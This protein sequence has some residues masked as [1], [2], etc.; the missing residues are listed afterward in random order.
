MTD[1]STR[2][3]LLWEVER[4]L[5]ELQSEHK[6]IDC[7]VM[8]NVPAI[9]SSKDYPNFEKWLIR[10]EELG[11]E[12][13]W[14]DINSKRMGI[15]QNRDRTFCVSVPKGY[16]VNKPKERKLKILLQDVL[17]ENVSEKYFLNDKMIDYIYREDDVGNYHRKAAREC[18][19]KSIEKGI[20]GS[21]PTDNFIKVKNATKKGYI[22]AEVGDGIDISSRMEK[23]RGTVQ[24]GMAQTIT[25]MGGDNIGVVVKDEKK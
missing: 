25:T 8:E 17:D 11:Y 16:Y 10:L 18:A 19:D 3:G 24:K 2:S 15:P 7:L 4:I 6:M 22:E 14:W 21:R 20:A 9:H 1:T 13:Y 5:T 23:H 12:S